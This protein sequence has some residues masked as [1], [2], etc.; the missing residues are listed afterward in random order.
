LA[1][2][3]ILRNHAQQCGETL[4][5]KNHLRIGGRLCVSSSKK[6]DAQTGRSIPWL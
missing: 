3:Q 5:V 1:L 4:G 6:N 2:T